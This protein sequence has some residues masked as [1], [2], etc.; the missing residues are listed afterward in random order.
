MK[1]LD[2]EFNKMVLDITNKLVPNYDISEN[3]PNT[4]NDMVD[5]FNNHG[6]LCIYNGSSDMTIFA[7]SNVNIAFRAWHDFYHLTKEL[8]FTDLGEYIV[9]NYQATDIMVYCIENNK[10]DKLNLWL[11]L[12]DIEINEQVKFF[13]E[14]NYFIEDQHKFTLEQLEKREIT[15]CN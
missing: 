14:N 10:L 2:I 5:Y 1:A 6:K 3:A 13:N 7:D 12:L 9:S 11:N 15:L 4:Y 8:Q